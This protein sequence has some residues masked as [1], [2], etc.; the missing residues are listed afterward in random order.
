MCFN[1]TFMELKVDFILSSAR[2]YVSF[3]RT[4]MEL[5]AIISSYDS[6]IVVFQSHLYGIERC[7]ER[8]QHQDQARFN[9]TFMELKVE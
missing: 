4:F 3:N 9:R 7:T 1:R 5:K 2:Q 8:S 6:L